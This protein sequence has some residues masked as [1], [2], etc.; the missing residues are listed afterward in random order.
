[1]ENLEKSNPLLELLRLTKFEVTDS[2]VQGANLLMNNPSM[3]PFMQ[4]LKNIGPENCVLP[5]K[6][7]KYKVCKQNK[8][9]SNI[10]HNVNLRP[11]GFGDI[12]CLEREIQEKDR[13][14]MEKRKVLQSMRNETTSLSE[15]FIPKAETKLST[16]NRTIEVNLANFIELNEELNTQN[17]ILHDNKQLMLNNLNKSDSSNEENSSDAMFCTFDFESSLHH[18]MQRMNTDFNV[19]C[20]FVNSNCNRSSN[21]VGLE[22][23]IELLGNS[24]SSLKTKLDEVKAENYASEKCA[25]KLMGLRKHLVNGTFKL[26]MFNNQVSS[27]QQLRTELNSVL[28]QIEDKHTAQSA[29]CTQSALRTLYSI[30]VSSLDSRITFLN[31]LATGMTCTLSFKH[32]LILLIEMEREWISQQCSLLDDV[33]EELDTV[34]SSLSKQE[35][36]LKHLLKADSSSKNKNSSESTAQVYGKELIGQYIRLAPD[37]TLD[38]AVNLLQERIRMEKERVKQEYCISSVY[39][40]LAPLRQKIQAQANTIYSGPTSVPIFPYRELNELVLTKT[41]RLNKL[42]AHYEQLLRDIETKRSEVQTET[43]VI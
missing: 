32:L 24:I 3:E 11:I 28:L 35:I 27:T 33:Y 6:L 8:F 18:L 34:N 22:F 7:I 25:A 17:R 2:I 9:R 38:T 16:E 43:N 42:K 15:D 20:K 41:L 13:V 36:N 29:R 4:S 40:K 26:N 23:D 19:L 21:D 14:L 1:M 5:E 31:D 39:E 10:K 12:E 37:D 30:R